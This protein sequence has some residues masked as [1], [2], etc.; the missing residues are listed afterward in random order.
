MSS[1]KALAFRAHGDENQ[2]E[3][4]DVPHPSFGDDDLLIKVSAFAI[5]PV[6]DLFLNLT[7][8]SSS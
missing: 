2:M 8:L 3:L 6:R 5:N 1:M 7:L 4:V